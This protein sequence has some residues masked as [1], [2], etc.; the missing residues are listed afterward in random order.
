[1]N[2]LLFEPNLQLTLNINNFIFFLDK[3]TIT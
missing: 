1:M 3:T 2:Y